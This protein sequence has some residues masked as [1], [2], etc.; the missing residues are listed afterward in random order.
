MPSGTV[1]WFSDEKGFGFITPDE[2]S[3]DLFVHH[4]SI[5]ADV[6][7]TEEHLEALAECALLHRC[8]SYLSNDRGLVDV[9]LLQERDRIVE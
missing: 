1:K 3:R 5:Q 7:S 4:T 8:S 6:G 9:Q 2:G